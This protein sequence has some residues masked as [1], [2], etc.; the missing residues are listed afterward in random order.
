MSG[1]NQLE[2]EIVS[3]AGNGFVMINSNGREVSDNM[4][5]VE[6]VEK[7]HQVILKKLLSGMFMVQV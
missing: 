3:G 1:F 5:G 4:I 2:G 7:L 6:D